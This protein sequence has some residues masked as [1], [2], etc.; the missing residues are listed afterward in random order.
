MR[1]L[2]LV[3]L[4]LL[5]AAFGFLWTSGRFLVVDRPGEA[6]VILVLAGET[7]VRPAR[8][9]E[10]ASRHYAPRVIL[11]VPAHD[12]IYSRSTLE[13]AEEYVGRLAERGSVSI[14]PI[15]G[16]STKAE[17]RDA[18][19]CLEPLKPHTVLLVTSDFHTR[20]ALSIFRHQLPQYQFSAAAAI[21]T[22]EFGT[23]WWRD[24]QW[25][26]TNFEEW[27]RLLWWETVDR[28]RS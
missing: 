26:K 16:L 24:R 2:R 27:L 22:V 17:T 4:L 10:L 13:L 18:Q 7:D 8:G 20:R 9:V 11:D 5:A 3:A 19:K 28:W 23:R 6:D 21:D 12:R 1:R 25:A 15:L 14:C